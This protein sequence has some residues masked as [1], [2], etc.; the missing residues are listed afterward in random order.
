[1]RYAATTPPR[2]VTLVLLS[3]LP[4]VSLNMFLPS[5]SDIAATFHAEFALVS[6]SIAGYAAMTAVLQLVMGPLSDRFGRRPVILAGMAVFTL[7]SLGCVLATDIWTFLLFRMVQGAVITGY[8]VSLAVIRDSAPAQRAASLMG[9]VATAWAVAPM[10]APMAGGAL[11]Q[12]FGWRAS[13]WA[14]LGFGLVAFGLSWVDLG[15]TNRARSET[16][17]TQV[18]TYPELFRSR[19]FW[20]YALCMAFSA[21]GF[22][23]F[24]S[25]APLVATAVFRMPPA[26]L[27]V[28]MGTITAGFVL[29]S[30]LSGRFAGRH[31][32]TTMM[33]AGRLAACAGL[34]A[35]LAFL[36]AG[37]VNV[38]TLFG[39][40]VF[41][42]VGNG[43]TMPS[44][45]AGAMSVRPRLAG[46]ASGVAGALTVAGGALMSAVTGAIVTAENG[47]YALLGTMLV[48]SVLALVAALYVLRLDRRGVQV[49]PSDG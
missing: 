8:T 24:L 13:F 47:A 32:L 16:F 46:S 40:C 49:I 48:S 29:G 9:Y 42:G 15:E 43:L 33:M 34:I 12:L 20:G 21:G 30:F 27:G 6:L 38:V 17:M 4:I 7:A 19:R 23:A 36:V 45:N 39:A 14:F 10:L 11:D 31:A 41:V 37:V 26:T 18:R 28:Y 5:L 22:Y 25:G 2:L 3:G 44:A 1:M 35:G